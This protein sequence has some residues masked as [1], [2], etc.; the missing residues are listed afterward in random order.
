[1]SDDVWDREQPMTE[2]ELAALREADAE[3]ADGDVITADE[4]QWF[5]DHPDEITDIDI[6]RMKRSTARRL[7]EIAPIEAE[8]AK[9]TAR[10]K[11]DTRARYLG[12]AFA[13][14][15]MA[16]GIATVFLVDHPEAMTKDPHPNHII[17]WVEK[18][19]RESA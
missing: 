12:P 17:A 16:P 10:E 6:E 13:A 11:L 19:R 15:G 14:A 5:D 4:W 8:R 7:A 2:A 18:F 9:R 3:D 1:V